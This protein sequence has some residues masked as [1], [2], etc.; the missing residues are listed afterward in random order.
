MCACVCVAVCAC[1]YVCVYARHRSSVSQQ[2]E[3]AA[4]AAAYITIS[5]VTDGPRPSRLTEIGGNSVGL[6]WKKLFYLAD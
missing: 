4:T 5:D 1:V 3:P 2:R 6:C